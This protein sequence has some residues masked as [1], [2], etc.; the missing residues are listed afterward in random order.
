M[1]SCRLHVRG[2]LII[3]PVL[4]FSVVYARQ[5]VKQYPFTADVFNCLADT[6][7]PPAIKNF[8]S[9]DVW[10]SQRRSRSAGY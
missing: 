5:D 2:V 8:H 7:A 9:S 4:L 6:R 10:L 3:N 1:T